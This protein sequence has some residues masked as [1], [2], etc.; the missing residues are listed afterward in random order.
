MR[1]GT[2]SDLHIDR[3]KWILEKDETTLS[4]LDTMV[5]AKAIDVL[6]IAGDIS[7]HYLESHAFL[8]E[9]SDK[10][11]IPVKFVPGNHDYWAKDHDVTDSHEINHFFNQQKY[12]LVGK[13]YDLNEDWAIVG[14]PGWYD[15]GYADHQ[16]YTEEQFEKKKYGFA[17][18]NDLHFVDWNQKDKEVSREMLSQLYRDLSTVKDKNIILMTHIATH[19]EF[20]VPLPHRIYDFANAFLG[21]K[22]YE[23]VYKDFESIKYSIMGHVHFRKIHHEEDKTFI[24][25]CLGSSKHWRDKRLKNQLE[26]SLFVFDI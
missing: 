21:A 13:P 9:L 23:K 22:S 11:G 18:W 6:L 26:R 12:S 1:I 14:T 25:P 19:K 10:S 8:E 7:N 15:Y 24:S 20:V 3:N 2:L 5:K 17:S 16:K 4:L